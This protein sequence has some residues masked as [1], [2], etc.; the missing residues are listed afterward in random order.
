MSTTSIWNA[1]YSIASHAPLLEVIDV[2]VVIVGAGITGLTTAFLLA[3]EGRSV[4]VIEANRVGAGVS[5]SSTGNLYQTVTGGLQALG[6]KWGDE[7][8]HAVVASRGEAM[9]FIES[10]VL[11]ARV[12]CAYRRCPMVH[13]AISP[14]GEQAVHDEFD[15]ARTAGLHVQL[16]FELPAALPS[17]HGAVLSIAHQAQFH[18]LAYMHALAS[19]TEGAGARIYEQ[20]PALEIDRSAVKVITP[21]GSIAA[22]DLVLATHSPSG[23]HMVQAGMG[24][25]REY[26]LSFQVD[27][28]PLPPGIF[29]GQ[30]MPRLSIRTL[31]F[32][33]EHY[34]LCIGEH[35]ET[36]RHDA[37]TVLAKLEQDARERLAVGDPVHR[38][39]AQHFHS[40]DGLPYIGRDESGAYIATGFSTDGLVYGT[41]AAQIMAD[42]IV[43]RANRWSS[44][45]R[46][47]RFDAFK[48]GAQT[49]KASSGVVKA[50]VHDYLTHRHA[51]P[52]KRLARGE[53]AI[54]ELENGR[55]AAYCEPNGRLHA[56]SP[57][58]TH[59]K[60][61]VHWNSVETSW[62]CPCHGSRFAPDGSVL[63][64]PALE[65]L[66]NRLSPPA[67]AD[68][69]RN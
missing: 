57:V 5:G 53:G 69:L 38:W 61:Q 63:E 10:M 28:P 7:V 39:S 24:A 55:V 68:S 58:C 60:C 44:V 11:K 1:T 6:S 35:H 67:D 2:D 62:D 59:M 49:M 27:A 43:G 23:F 8:T 64:G 51:E 30:G 41:L 32:N 15:A 54:V 22:R 13:Y 36:G 66:V 20:S 26:G 19:Q 56:V 17:A 65:P 52:L 34:L 31:D 9:S 25:R 18:P 21:C 12:P 50:L 14:D 42:R 16:G 40:P 4:A 45:Y 29:W 47:R 48:A 3:E 46:A 37:A 33:G